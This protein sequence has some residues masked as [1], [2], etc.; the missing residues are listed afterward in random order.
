[1]SMAEE[2]EG[3]ERRTSREVAERVLGLLAT[4]GKVH[5]P[6]ESATW[7]NHKEIHQHLSPLEKRFVDSENPSE[8]DRVIFSWRA[9]ALV[10][11]LWSL[12]GLSDMPALD[13]QFETYQNAMVVRAT[14]QT[15]CFL[16]EA[17]LR[18]EEELDEMEHY[19][20][21]QHWRVRDHELG[22]G[23]DKPGEDDPDVSR[24]DPGIV[25]E[26]R[27]GMSWVTGSGETWDDVPT[28]T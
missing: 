1:M 8:Q 27:Y 20:Y 17:Q 18:G 22:L 6:E 11:L 2:Q 15:K 26:R 10:S 12:N 9:E 25:Y 5:F 16:E 21:H 4:L 19:L 28:D 7:I 24:L 14:T 23:M 3:F 13:E